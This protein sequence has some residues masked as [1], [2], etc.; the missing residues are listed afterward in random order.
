MDDCPHEDCIPPGTDYTYAVDR[1][2]IE[3]EALD[4][5][6]DEQNLPDNELG[7]FLEAISFRAPGLDV[8]A[9]IDESIAG[10]SLVLLNRVNAFSLE[11]APFVHC[12]WYLGDADHVLLADSP[13]NVRL[14]GTIYEGIYFGGPGDAIVQLSWEGAATPLRIPLVGARLRG[15]I[16]ETEIGTYKAPARLAAGIAVQDF[17]VNI[18]PSLFQIL[19]DLV[20]ADCATPCACE[21]GSAGAIALQLFD[22][23]PD[24]AITFDEL[25]NSSL[26]AE[27]TFNAI[28]LLDAEG[29]FNPRSDLTVDSF[30][31]TVGFTSKAASFD[32]PFDPN[33]DQ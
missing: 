8:Q 32:F 10:G 5:D 4:I 26:L 23:Q 28:D 33:V 15:S 29:N 31:I 24:C 17:F 2:E 27:L 30:P 11:T 7:R 1:V 6:G 19:D 25:Q 21:P 18:L 16:S 20:A 9:W 13:G 12:W 14:T 3:A 22:D